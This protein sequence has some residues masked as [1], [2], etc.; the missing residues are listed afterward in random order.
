MLKKS[1]TLAHVYVYLKLDFE[2]RERM[3]KI[4]PNGLNVREFTVRSCEELNE[5][6]YYV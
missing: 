1:F 5:Y 4:D 3:V 2:R 6:A